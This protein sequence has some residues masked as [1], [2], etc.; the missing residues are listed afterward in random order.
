MADTTNS[1][2]PISPVPPVP[3]TTP[4]GA[5]SS[6]PA[7]GDDSSAEGSPYKDE[8]K[9]RF[10]AALDEAKAGATAL[11]DEALTRASS[12]RDQAKSKGDYWTADAK[13]KSR[14]LAA[15]G[16]AKA[17]SALTGLSRLVEENAT[18]IDE[19]LGPKYGDYARDASRTIRD[20]ADSLDRKSVEELGED[21]RTFVREKP[22]TAVGVAALVGF[23]FAS[24]FR[25]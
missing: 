18:K 5:T 14:D 22:G 17:S 21:A 7:W 4:L 13:G 15:E 1:N 24:L 3:N 10:N 19:N 8:A 20:T 12:Y 25:K 11:K 2:A 6:A 23:V 9:S 16:K